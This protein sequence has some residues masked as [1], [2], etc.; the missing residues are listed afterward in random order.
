M[1]KILLQNRTMEGADDLN[2][3]IAGFLQKGLDLGAIL[4]YDADM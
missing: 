1:A 2:I 4:A 3:Q